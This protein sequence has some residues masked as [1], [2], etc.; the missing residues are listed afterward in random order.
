MLRP[1]GV[2][3]VPSA[4]AVALAAGADLS[5]PLLVVD[6]G[7]HLTEAVLLRGAVTDARCTALGT[8]DADDTTSAGHLRRGLLMLT[9]MLRQDSTSLT[10]PPCTAASSWPAEAHCAPTSPTTSPAACAHR[11]RRPGPAHRGRPRRR[12]ASARGPHPPF[13]LRS[14][15]TGGRAATFVALVKS[16]T[17]MLPNTPPPPRA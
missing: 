1:R 6:I 11:S 2:L 16:G 14:D 8:G 3:T 12:R 9:A 10:P 4:R 5:P 17:S 7:A 15:L 13:G